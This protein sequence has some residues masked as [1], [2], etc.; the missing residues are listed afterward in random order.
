MGVPAFFRWLQQK[1][2]KT[3]VAVVEEDSIECE[4]GQLPGQNVDI[5][6]PNPNHIEFDCL[7]VDMNGCVS[8]ACG[9]L[10]PVLWLNFTGVNCGTRSVIHPCVHPEDGPAPDTEEK[11]FEAVCRYLDRIVAAARP[12]RLLYLAIDGV[13]PRAKMNQQRSRRFKAAKEMQDAEEVED[14]KRRE[15]AARGVPLPPK[16]SSTFDHNVITPGTG[17][18]PLPPRDRIAH[19]VLQPLVRVSPRRLHGQ[20]VQVRAALDLQPADEQS[21]LEGLAGH[22]L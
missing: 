8:A 16:K 21:R 9:R 13:A 4:A 12:R 5:S 7:Y 3:L 2:P 11:M 1:Y 10:P 14:E 19:S 15:L 6:G 20:P 22:L 17:W 18:W